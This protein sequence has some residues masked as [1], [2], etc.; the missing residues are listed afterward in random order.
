MSADTSEL[1][2]LAGDLDEASRQVVEKILPVLHR[3]ANNIVRDA[4]E[5]APQSAVIRYYPRTITYDIERDGGD[6]V[7]EIGP[8]R[9]KNGQA[10]LGHLFEYGTA[11]LAPRPHLGP[12]LD[13]ELPTF[14]RYAADAVTEDIRR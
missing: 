14:E 2:D 11:S 4:R 13:R 7:A 8:D 1:D 3:G 5:N 6:L 9:D 10:K 12:A